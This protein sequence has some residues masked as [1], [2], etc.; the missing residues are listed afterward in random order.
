MHKVDM[1]IKEAMADPKMK[2]QEEM[3]MQE[4]EMAMKAKEKGDII[5]CRKH[6]NMAQEDLMSHG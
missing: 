2:K 4:S 5:G 1:M 6:L 3:A